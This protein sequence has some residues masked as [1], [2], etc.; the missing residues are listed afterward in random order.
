MGL[1]SDK[2]VIIMKDSNSAKDYLAQLEEL[3]PRATGNTKKEIEKEIMITK[4]G[5]IGEDN[6]LFEL[7]NSGMDLVVLHDLYLETTNDL[8]AQIDF[9]VITN[10]I[11]FV[12]ECKNLFGNIEIRS[13]G[14]FI[15]TIQYGN[16]YY[17]EGIY[18]P[19]TQNERHLQVMKEK[20]AESQNALLKLISGSGFADVYKSLVVLANP[21]TVLNSR[22]AKREVKDKV[23]RA[24]QLITTMK[25]MNA[26]SNVYKSSLNEMKEYGEKWL[27]RSVENETNRIEKFKLMA[28]NDEQLAG[29]QSIEKDKTAKTEKN[30][31]QRT[32]P[33]CGGQLLLREATRGEHAGQKFWGCSNYPHC[34]YIESYKG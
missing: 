31:K 8:S 25:E 13:N 12:L 19:I 2:E 20:R 33:R 1:F 14:D 22:Y 18:S 17:R 27:T 23:I 10:K 26:H 24:D 30:E 4:A 6:I 28:E 15:R 9:L 16:R 21:K 29:K 32:C 3:L 5:I 7:K 34:R 11:C